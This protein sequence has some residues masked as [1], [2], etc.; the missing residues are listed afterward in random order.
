MYQSPGCVCVDISSTTYHLFTSAFVCALSPLSVCAYVCVISFAFAYVGMTPD[1]S[2]SSSFNGTVSFAV[3]NLMYTKGLAV[4][5]V[6]MFCSQH[7]NG[8][9]SWRCLFQYLHT[10]ISEVQGHLPALLCVSQ[11]GYTL[12]SQL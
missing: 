7:T 8:R 5:G 6:V 11:H 3:G 1:T 4:S 12:T 9:F 2:S 10:M